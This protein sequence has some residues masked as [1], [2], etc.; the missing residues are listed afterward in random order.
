MLFFFSD[1]IIH[2]LAQNKMI[3][4][5]LDYGNNHKTIIPFNVEIVIISHDCCSCAFTELKAKR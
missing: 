4:V 1:I 3:V 2:S 5:L